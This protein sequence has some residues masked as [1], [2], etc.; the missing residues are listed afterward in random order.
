MR[1]LIIAVLFSLWVFSQPAEAQ[2]SHKEGDPAPPAEGFLVQPFSK[3][4]WEASN[5]A[6]D[7]D[8]RWFRDAKYGMFIHF[9]L[10]THN[11]ADL[12]W[13]VCQT[14]K[15]PDQGQGPVPDADWQRWP[16]E[17]K[18]ERFDAKEWVAIAREAGF[19]YLVAIAKH[20]D[21][22]HLWDTAFSDFKVTRTPFK[23]DYLKELADACHAVEMPFGIYYSQRDWYH[24]DYM[25]VDP[26]KV[27]QRGLQWT[28]KPGE[29][30]PMGD[31]HR[32][33]NDYQFNVC[34]ELCTKYGKV[35]ILWWD[36]AWWGGMF[37]PE[38][39]DAEKL[40]RLVR[41]L[42]PGILLNNRCSVPGD[43]DTPEQRLGY[44]QDWR[45]W[46][47]CMCLTHSW[48]YSATPPKPR[49]QIIRMLVNN[50]CCDGNL[51]LSWGPKWD[52]EFDQAEKQRLLEVG[53]WLKDHGQAL[54]GTRGGPW[55]LAAWGGST[56]RGNTVWL[57]VMKWAGETLTLP[58]LP[59]RTVVSARLLN[60]ARVAFQQTGSAL[61]LVV[62]ENSQVAPA[63]IVELT[64]DRPLDDVQA[65][66]G[67]QLSIFH[68]AVTYGQIVSRQAKVKT[69][70]TSP[71][72][73]PAGPAALVA[74][75]PA[76]DFAFHTAAEENPWVEIDLG[77]KVS[78]TG[79][80]VFN[81]IGAGE[82]GQDRAA[83]L[84]LSVSISGKTWQEVWRA[85]RSAPQWEIP[86]NDFLAGAL[87]PGRKARY[88]RL[89][90][91]PGKPDYFHL[92]QVE[93]WGK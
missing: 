7:K 84:R 21:G 12:S 43:F 15:A 46:E 83:T 36:A 88:L 85:S 70:S 24:P 34:R 58:A 28:L 57:H 55:R 73:P 92:R 10:S 90:T 26:A 47:S 71:Y 64:C 82:P 86:V 60:G 18:F 29:V 53:A 17:F 67:D 13:G 77:R 40:T 91:R 4:E 44:Y 45:P 8:L 41:E 37:T 19:K 48:S 72:D 25:P 22:F 32:K 56:R 63:T 76:A 80:R 3:T 62:P 20:H 11:N 30:S 16:E 6:P 52:G 50:A 51:L 65:L 39:W 93:V 27:N 38:M 31:R 1:P 2:W 5:F 59:E 33:Y 14:R 66:G 89:E 42:Q 49:D 78:V 87:V 35:D 75:T 69:S 79:V 61:K 23:R 68:D 9:G 74:A 54:Y 81:R